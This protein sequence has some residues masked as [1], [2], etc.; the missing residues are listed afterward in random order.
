MSD[1]AEQFHNA[2]RSVFGNVD[3][4]LLC[5][6]HVDRAWREKL[7]LIKDKETQMIVY[8]SLRLLMEETEVKKFE[9]L[10]TKT[11]QQLQTNATT[12]EFGQYFIN[13]YMRRKEQWASCYRQQSFINTNMHVEAFHHVLKYIYLNGKVNKRVDNC[14]H[15]LLKIT[16][17]KNFERIIKLTKG[18]KNKE[19]HG[20]TEKGTVPVKI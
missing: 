10:L 1:D 17:D 15:T 9:M 2:W 18:K 8:H 11:V 12:A 16:R 19:S 13:T 20:N 7:T 4:K 6:W 3:N 14:I 5:T